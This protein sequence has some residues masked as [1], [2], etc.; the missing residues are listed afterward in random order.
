MWGVVLIMAVAARHA[1][2]ECL[3][4]VEAFIDESNG[5]VDEAGFLELAMA[6]QV[7]LVVTFT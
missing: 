4:G 7:R 3:P 5:V 2:A 1:A 6:V